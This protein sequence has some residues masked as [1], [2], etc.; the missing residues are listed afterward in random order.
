MTVKR[1][2]AVR[3]I[4]FD[5]FFVIAEEFLCLLLR[6]IAKEKVLEERSIDACRREN[7]FDTYTHR[8]SGV[9]A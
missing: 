6:E 7:E 4:Y 9:I 3:M 8:L 1:S 5:A 2:N